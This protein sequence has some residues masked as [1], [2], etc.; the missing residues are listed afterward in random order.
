M[1]QP[2]NGV[3]AN[4][5]RFLPG[6]PFDPPRAGI[7]A[8]NP[9]G[10]VSLFTFDF[11]NLR[12]PS[13]NSPDVS[14]VRKPNCLHEMPDF[15]GTWHET[16]LSLRPKIN[17][18]IGNFLWGRSKCQPNSGQSRLPVRSTDSL[19]V[20][21]SRGAIVRKSITSAWMPLSDRTSAARRHSSVM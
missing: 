13:L 17:T 2:N 14:L 16:S 7:R 9:I 12:N 11:H 18:K 10:F 1:D 15:V 6:M 3:P 5:R 8:T 4:L 20:S 19:M 21:K